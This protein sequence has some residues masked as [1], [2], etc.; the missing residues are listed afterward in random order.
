LI[1]AFYPLRGKHLAEVQQRVLELH[2][3]KHAQL[4]SQD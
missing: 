2:A 1:L 3:Q 4:N